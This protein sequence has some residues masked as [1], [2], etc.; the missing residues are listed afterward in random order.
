MENMNIDNQ[1]VSPSKETNTQN[2][3]AF[4]GGVTEHAADNTASTSNSQETRE[5][6]FSSDHAQEPIRDSADSGFAT[7]QEPT[8]T[9]NNTPMVFEENL[10]TVDEKSLSSTTATMDI[11]TKENTNST[12]NIQNTNTTA[13]NLTTNQEQSEIKAKEKE[14]NP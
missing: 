14:L 10:R 4:V 12:E 5:T 7:I 13:D 2:V 8:D 1:E 3:D 6:T 9:N 11:D